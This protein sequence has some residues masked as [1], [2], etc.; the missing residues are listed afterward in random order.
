M[1]RKEYIEAKFTTH[2]AKFAGQSREKLNF[3]SRKIE[4]SHGIV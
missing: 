2:Q 1:D 4:C 3:I